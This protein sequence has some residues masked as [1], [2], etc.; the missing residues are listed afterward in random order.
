MN[1]YIAKPIDE[2]LL[3]R[4]IIGLVKKTTSHNGYVEI[5]GIKNIK[6]TDLGDLTRRT[7]SNPDLIM[8]MISLFLLQTPALVKTM[9]R[10]LIDKDWISMG[11]AAHK[12]IPS[13]SIMGINTKYE[14]MA[15]QVQQYAGENDHL[16]R[17]PDLIM[18]LEN[19]CAQACTELEEEH[20]LVKKI[21]S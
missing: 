2:R 17:I 13:F 18:Q 9:K 7:K 19:V 14:T 10:N 1:D 11:S 15:R 16:E 8:E 3:Y 20:K 21:E 4:K 12:M 6:C 5:N